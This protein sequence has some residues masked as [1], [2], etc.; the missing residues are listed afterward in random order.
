MIDADTIKRD[1]R[2]IRACRSADELNAYEA[3]ARLRG[4]DQHEVTA[5]AEMRRRHGW[6]GERT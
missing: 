5:I 2:N 4:L 6:K 3:D 1:T